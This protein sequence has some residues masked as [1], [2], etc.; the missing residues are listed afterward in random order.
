[1]QAQSQVTVP[2]C[3]F[4]SN[5]LQPKRRYSLQHLDEAEGAA[6]TGL[7]RDPWYLLEVGIPEHTHPFDC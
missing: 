1:M 3:A 2:E 4:D 6:K 5:H 7:S